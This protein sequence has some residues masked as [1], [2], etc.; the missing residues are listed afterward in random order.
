[1]AVSLNQDGIV[2][3]GPLGITDYPFT[4]VG[5][6]RVPSVSSPLTL[7]RID[8]TATTS[9]HYIM[10]EGHLTGQVLAGIKIGTV[11]GART[12]A[13]MVPGQWHHVVAVFEAYNSRRVYLDGGNMDSSGHIRVFDGADQFRAG[14]INSS[15]AVDMAE[16]A[17]VAAVLSDN[18]IAILARGGPMLSLPRA[19]ELLTYHDCVRRINRPGV[20]PL[21]SSAVSLTVVDH[22]RV[23]MSC[24]GLSFAQPSRTCGP[25][26]IDQESYVSSFSE[27]GQLAAAGVADG[28]G[29]AVTAGIASEGSVLFGEVL[30]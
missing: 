15:T 2:D 26:Q 29:Q 25:L 12:T 13:P 10:Y 17:I 27:Q 20:G 19:A 11:I 7:M 8:N 28:V 16:I 9:F 22:P 30:C 6:F 21:A 4:M 5:W 1:M 24:G 23:L 14:N 3:L 18:E